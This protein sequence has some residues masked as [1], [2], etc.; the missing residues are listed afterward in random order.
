MEVFLSE[1]G[2]S[3]FS[4]FLPSVPQGKE[5]NDIITF[6]GINSSSFISSG[7]FGSLYL[8][9]T[10]VDTSSG[11]ARGKDLSFGPLLTYGSLIV[12]RINQLVDSQK[13]KFFLNFKSL[14]PAFQ[15]RIFAISPNCLMI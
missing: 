1:S 10:G 5:K 11:G 14:V 4:L 6:T 13:V 7:D 9:W 3:I 2:E 8:L 12:K 15:L